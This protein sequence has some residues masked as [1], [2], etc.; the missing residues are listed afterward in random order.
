MLLFDVLYVER[1]VLRKK[2]IWMTRFNVNIPVKLVSLKVFYSQTKILYS[3]CSNVM[4]REI[5]ILI[6]IISILKK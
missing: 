6:S 4:A 3:I 2:A 5:T 1:N